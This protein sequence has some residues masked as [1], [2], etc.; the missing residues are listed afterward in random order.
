MRKIIVISLIGLFFLVGLGILFY[1]MIADYVNARNQS[2]VI[3]SYYD[4]IAQISEEDYTQLIEE[5][6]EYNMSLLTNENRFKF[7]DEDREK[8]NKLLTPKGKQ[9]MGILEIEAIG[10]KLPIYHGTSEGVLQVGIGHI[11][12][13][14]LPIGGL[15]T[16]SALSGHRGLPS[17]TLLTHLDKLVVG[18]TFT[19][20]IL[21]EILTYQVDQIVVA[22]PD[23]MSEMAIDKD[24]DYC[25]LVT[26]TPYGIN[27]HRMLVR[28][29]RIETIQATDAKPTVNRILESDAHQYNTFSIVGTVTAIALIPSVIVG[30]ISYIRYSMK[31]K[32]L[33]KKLKGG[34]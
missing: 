15:G 13:S 28:G 6:T 17:A 3:A 7:T 8:Y 11:E 24:K 23:D 16:H 9:I 20:H 14:S 18:D 33:I 22:E 29:V 27:S 1:P 12:G 26:C 4:D 21:N 2:R 25:T 32:K 31:I 34:R 30:I 19:L 5:A 10:V